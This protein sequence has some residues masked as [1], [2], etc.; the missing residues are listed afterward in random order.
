[1]KCGYGIFMDVP[2]TIRK[3]VKTR[4]IFMDAGRRVFVR[5]GYLNT[6]ISEI[7][8]EAGK[9][10]GTFYIY[11]ENKSALLDSMIEE[12]ENHIRARFQEHDDKS[13]A[14][15]QA[16]EWGLMVK[17]MWETFQKHAAMFHALAQAS[18]IDQHFA[19]AYAA[20][21]QRT[22]ADFVSFLRA[23]QKAGFCKTLH[24]GYA[25]AAL[26]TMVVYSMNEWL[27]EGG[28]CQDR[29]EEKRA[30]NTLTA[31]FEHAMSTP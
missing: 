19:T 15:A 7:A 20:I 4:Q 6:E 31:I 24:P 3:G 14:A 27:A 8:R 16:Q 29:R 25:A 11:F 30:L 22:R 17:N 12:F 5:D 21:R 18:L 28:K 26:E 9:S 23:R 10:N 2:I 13:F 1:M